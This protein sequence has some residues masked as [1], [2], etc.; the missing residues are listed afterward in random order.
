MKKSAAISDISCQTL[1]IG[2]HTRWTLIRVTCSDG[3]IGVGEASA[4]GHDGA[5]H[6]YCKQAKE[7]LTGSE[8]LPNAAA[9]ILGRARNGLAQAAIASAV[10]QAL[11]DALGKRFGV[12]V[13][14]LLGGAIADSVELYA[15][16]NR[17][18][19]D[20]TPQGFIE[21]ALMAKNAGFRFIKLAPFDDISIQSTMSDDTSLRRALHTVGAVCDAV[22]PE[23]AVMIDCHWNLDERRSAIVLEYAAERGLFWVEC[24]IP[25]TPEFL[26]QQRRLKS[27]A[28]ALGVRLAGQER[29]LSPE[30]VRPYIDEGLFDV[31]MPDV[32]YIGGVSDLHTLARTAE[33]AGIAISPHNPTGPICHA[34]SVHIASTLS[35]LLLL[36]V[37]F[38]E[39]PVFSELIGGEM[40]LSDG[41][42]QL[43]DGPGF[44]VTLDEAVAARLDAS[45][46]D[47]VPHSKGLR[48]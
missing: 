12:R 18:T 35:N 4:N 33:A 22:G 1:R 45:V 16:I 26:P 48:S 11:W 40:A 17:R 7:A 38:G 28:G 8:A 15:N 21:S 5:L 46:S 6:A 30:S 36:E 24:P 42:A 2:K 31:L 9:K 14:D 43:P 41:Y 19:R 44:G 34:A 39:S 25:E 3:I 29:A 20:R 10:D 13:C 27:R 37:Q 47:V 32:K 23:I